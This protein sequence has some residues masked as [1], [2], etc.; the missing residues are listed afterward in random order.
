V[1]AYPISIDTGWPLVW[2]VGGLSVGLLIA[3]LVS[4]LVGRLIQDQ[5]GRRVL[6]ASALLLSAGLLILSVSQNVPIYIL[7]WLM[8]GCG[9]GAGLYDA[10]FST[11]GKLYGYEAR[12]GIATVTLFGGF[13]STACWPISAFLVSELGWRGACAVYAAIHLLIVLP[14]YLLA[15]PREANS[16]PTSS[17]SDSSSDRADTGSTTSVTFLLLA[18]TVTITAVIS[19][20]IAVHLLT[21]L[22]ARDIALAA[23]V[24]LG[25]MIGPSQVGARF[26]ETL[27]GK[28]HHPIWTLLASTVAVAVGLGAL[29]SGLG[30]VSAALIFYGAGIG[31]ESIAR[32]T[33]PLTLFGPK[34]YA[35]IMGKLAMP[36]LLAQ[37]AAPSLSAALLNAFGPHK[38]LMLLMATAIA[39]VGLV[40]ALLA[41]SRRVTT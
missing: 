17:T 37:A 34:H 9:M 26:V 25:A 4:P 15:L 2:V 32:A 35:P 14:S 30:V 33:L 27:I 10:A 16:A 13:A 31:I 6:S 18:A 3:G 19:T 21:I 41:S 11:L 36:S 40:L 12:S 20:V 28:Y 5:G 38:L 23:A 22:Q 24:A 7:G 39:N 8:I 29:W 1:L